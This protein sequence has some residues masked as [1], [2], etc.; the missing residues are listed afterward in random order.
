[1]GKNT[2]PHGSSITFS[3]C[4]PHSSR[5][6]NLSEIHLLF[7]PPV[8]NLFIR[9]LLLVSRLIHKPTKEQP[10]QSTRS[11][12]LFNALPTLFVHVA[13]AVGKQATENTALVGRR[14]L[15]VQLASLEETNRA[16]DTYSPPSG[17]GGRHS[18]WS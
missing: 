11:L 6:L 18:S 16:R 17:D 9:L 14:G 1:M 8:S 10:A 13:A 12:H 7:P 2:Q 3:F 5:P 15:E 4:H